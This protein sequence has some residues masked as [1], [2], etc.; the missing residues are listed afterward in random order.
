MRRHTL[1]ALAL[2]LAAASAC[3]SGP[4][5]PGTLNATVTS[6]QPLGALVLDFTGGA[7]TGF[8][9]QG[10]TQVYSADLG[11]TQPH[12]RVILLSP[13]GGQIRFGIEVSDVQ[14]ERPV[15]TAVTGATPTNQQVTPSGL[16]VRI[17][18]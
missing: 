4:K 3:D 14:A 8:E 17:G 12:H 1:L 15:V 10:D 11:G 16:Q 7:V 9:G 18:G 6:P 13:S 5:G 2:L